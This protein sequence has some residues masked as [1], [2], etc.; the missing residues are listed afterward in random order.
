MFPSYQG[1]ELCFQISSNDNIPQQDLILPPTTT[2]TTN[3]LINYHLH[4]ATTTTSGRR[5][6]KNPA[7]AMDADS[8]SKKVMHRDTERQRR[9]EMSALYASLRS[10]LP[11]EFV[12][13][14]RSMSDHMNEAVNYINVLKRRIREL[15]GKRSEV[16]ALTNG[17]GNG[18]D[19]VNDAARLNVLPNGSGAANS[20]VE[21]RRCLAG[22]EVVLTSSEVVGWRVS[23]VMRVMMEEGLTVV[24]CNS[25]RVN[26]TCFHTLL[27]EVE[28]PTNLNTHALQQ[29]LIP[30]LVSSSSSSSG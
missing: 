22:V 30:L 18:N 3:P 4:G 14:K 9:Q 7:A 11:L 20:S 26:G 13:G 25:T 15:E 16:N 27:A 23:G 2:T 8:N 19:I 29:K 5:R 10:L 17:N 6:R 28:D 1:N 12:K 24:N 21:V